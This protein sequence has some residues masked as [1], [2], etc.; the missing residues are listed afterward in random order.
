MKM[1]R[2]LLVGFYTASTLFAGTI[3]SLAAVEQTPTTKSEEPT[4]PVAS[5]QQ[6]AKEGYSCDDPRASF[7][8]V[9]VD[10]TDLY[11]KSDEGKDVIMIVLDPHGKMVG[12]DRMYVKK[13]STDIYEHASS[14]LGI[15]PR[16]PGEDSKA[17]KRAKS[18]AITKCGFKL[19]R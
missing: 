9:Y 1:P 18:I 12:A 14:D 3:A 4:G 10:V 2:S 17:I 11:S 7:K 16:Y 8:K 15:D 5:P 13:I 6:A 19:G